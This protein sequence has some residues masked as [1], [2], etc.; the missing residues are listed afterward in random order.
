M[1]RKIKTF[2]QIYFIS[3][4]TKINILVAEQQQRQIKVEAQWYKTYEM[5][6]KQF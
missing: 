6:Q 1:K 2:V 4:N 3:M 5:Q